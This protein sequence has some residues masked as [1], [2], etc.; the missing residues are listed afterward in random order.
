MQTQGILT[1][2][3][4]FC[5]SHHPHLHL[6][7][8][9]F[10]YFLLPGGG[11]LFIL[12]IINGHVPKHHCQKTLGG[13]SDVR[14]LLESPGSELHCHNPLGRMSDVRK[15]LESPR[16]EHYCHNPLGG[17]SNVRKLSESQWVACRGAVRIHID[18]FIII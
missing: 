3:H 9:N 1:F 16:S 13:I 7:C 10:L 11:N 12:N 15:L 2:E 5:Q 14:K 18:W 17:M 6:L 8:Q 4:F